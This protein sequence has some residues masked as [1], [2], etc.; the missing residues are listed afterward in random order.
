MHHMLRQSQLSYRR[1]SLRKEMLV[2]S[3]QKQPAAAEKSNVRQDY[4]DDSFGL[5]FLSSP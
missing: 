1:M 5:G 4:E 2:R 3:S